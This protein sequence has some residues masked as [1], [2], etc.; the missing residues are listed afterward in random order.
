MASLSLSAVRAEIKAHP[1]EH[2]T[3]IL[4]D[5]CGAPFYVG[6][7]TGRRIRLHEAH[8]LSGRATS[9]ASAIR[10][11]HAAGGTV[12]YQIA[13][14]FSDWESAA[15]EERRLIAEIGRSDKNAGPLVNRTNG[16]QGLAGAIYAASPARAEGARR[17]AEK[18]RGRKLTAEHRA[19]IGVSGKGRKVSPETGVKISAALKGKPL[20]A[21]TRLKQSEAKLG[22]S[23]P[24]GA[25]DARD[26]WFEANRE[27]MRAERAA[28]WRDPAYRDKTMKSLAA[29]A[30]RRRQQKTIQRPA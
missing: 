29:A 20:S 21:A 10:A 24:P 30:E 6:V 26:A 4:T 3:Y 23:M 5:Q 13:G 7:G 2:Y 1:G 11:I 8:A 9:A 15:S 28:R 17:A 22:R 27:A 25:N 12:A 16:G 19:K 18:N 14:W